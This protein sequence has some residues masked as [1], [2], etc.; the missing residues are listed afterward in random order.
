MKFREGE[1]V[2]IVGSAYKC[3]DCGGNHGRY[4]HGGQLDEVKPKSHGRILRVVSEDKLLLRLKD[5]REWWLHPD[6]LDFL[7][8]GQMA[9]LRRLLPGMQNLPKHPV[10]EIAE[11]APVFLVDD[12]VYSLGEGTP[13]DGENFYEQNKRIRSTRT[14]LVEVGDLDS[15]EALTLDR[16]QPDMERIG[17]AYVKEAQKELNVL[18][19]LEGD[20]DT[21]QLIFK[22]VFPYLQD[23]H[24]TDR[25]S[26]L[27]GAEERKEVAEAEKPQEVKVE[28]TQKLEQIADEI[29]IEV[30]DLIGRIE[31]EGQELAE[32]SKKQSKLDNLFGYEEPKPYTGTSLLGRALNGRNVAIVEGTVCDLITGNDGFKKHVQIGGQRFSLV[33]RDEP[34]RE[35]KTEF[36]VGDRIRMNAKANG[37]YS[38]TKEGSEGVIKDD[39]GDGAFQVEF[40]KL[41][42]D[43]EES[44]V[45]PINRKYMENLAEIV[46]G[47]G[48]TPKDLEDRFIVELG[49]KIRVDALRE[50]LSRDK[51]V[52][53]LRTQEAELLA[54]AGKREYKGE[55]FGFT[56]DRGGNYYAYLEVP[57]F[58]IKSQFDGNHYLFDR[59][60]IGIKVGWRGGE[61][62]Y[63]KLVMIDN[64]NHPFLHNGEGSFVELCLGGLNFPISGKH[65]G[66]VI[67]KRLR[68][69]REMVMFGY[70]GHDYDYSYKL[71]DNGHFDRNRTDLKKLEEMG[72]LIIQGGSRE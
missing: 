18:N 49:R 48:A 10:F 15:L 9:K 20:L 5:R 45:W 36:E 46:T 35:P 51:I 44:N 19:R 2:V 41:T 6:E 24:Y 64:N 43:L 47:N 34:K 3:N 70:A 39:L 30:R 67:A 38:I 40:T 65:N 59:A 13:Q 66:E 17:E 33:E 58:A 63:N 1:D 50:Y 68:R 25:V 11:Q 22:Q 26:E 27:L 60:R 28:I 56:Q 12:K 14:S 37:Q 53:L 69:G 61:L 31:E 42:S 71:T 8:K 16:A 23:K 32:R 29:E 52:D 21:P 55:G 4:Y 7:D 54:M 72:V 62:V 57:A